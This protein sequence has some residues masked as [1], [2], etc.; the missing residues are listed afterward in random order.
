MSGTVP[1]PPVGLPP[2]PRRLRRLRSTIF[3][4]VGAVAFAVLAVIVY[5]IA[6]V[7]DQPT[8]ETAPPPTAA[9]PTASGGS[10]AAILAMAP[11]GAEIP[12]QRRIPPPRTV[13]PQPSPAPAPQPVQAHPQPP[14]QPPPEDDIAAAAR[15][16]AWT[17]YYGDLT[18]FD[19]KRAEERRAAMA[20]D[21]HPKEQAENPAP[22]LPPG[23]PPPPGAQPPKDF[24]SSVASDPSRDYLQYSLTDPLSD[25][26]LKQGDVIAAILESGLTSDSPGQVRAMVKNDVKDYRTGDHIL[27]PAGS[28]LV[29]TYDTAMAYGQTRIMVAWTRIIYPR[30]CAQSLDLG[31][32]TGSD[33]TGQAGFS[34]MTD[35][36]LGKVFTNALLLSLLSAGIQLSQPPQSSFQQYSP[37]QSAGGAIGQ[38]MG[39]LGMEMA[40]KGMSIPPTERIRQGYPFAVMISKDIAF[41]HPW[42]DGQCD[43]N[44]VTVAQ[45]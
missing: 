5:T 36:H 21:V 25:Y 35:N 2:P 20:S 13:F 39:Q 14:A 40:R 29:G 27:I 44:S 45:K 26:E 24:L 10:A 23:I 19:S 3:W 42:V 4:L 12:A 34:D 18:K 31:A 32:M 43:G 9:A 38:Q 15:R 11:L 30:P 16:S 37:V 8:T 33:Q 22:G 6:H 17:Q 28:R 1:P 7:G 41:D